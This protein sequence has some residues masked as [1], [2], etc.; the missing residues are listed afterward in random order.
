[1]IGWLL[2]GWALAGSPCELPPNAPLIE[3]EDY[4]PHEAAAV[5]CMRALL[6]DP[7]LDESNERAAEHAFLT[8]WLTGVPYVTITVRLGGAVKPALKKAR[9]DPDLSTTYVYGLAVARLTDPDADP[10]AIE[11]AGLRAMVRRYESLRQRGAVPR[12]RVIEGWAEG[13]L[14]TVAAES[15][16]TMERKN[17]ER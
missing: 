2:T 16:A 15:V 7:V 8:R 10:V 5:S 1:M 9:H 17:A 3:A 4:A 13:D 11:K 14:Q 12:N 6:A